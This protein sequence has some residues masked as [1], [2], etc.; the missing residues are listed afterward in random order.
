MGTHVMSCA[1]TATD[2]AIG[3]DGRV[4]IEGIDL[5]LRPSELVALIGN[6]GTGKSTLLD[7]LAGLRSPM[8][9]HVTTEGRDVRALS[10]RDRARR[11]AQV[12]TVRPRSGLLTVSALVALGRHP[13]TDALGR[14]SEGDRKAV[15]DALASVDGISLADRAVATLS[16]GE[17]QKVMIARALAQDTPILLL[18]EPTAHL[19]ITNRAMVFAL[20]RRVATQRH[21]AIVCATHD[22]QHALALADRIL[23][24]RRDGGP[25]LGDPRMAVREGVIAAA[26]DGPD[27][28][29]DPATGAFRVFRNDGPPLTGGGPG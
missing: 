3:H 21:K 7:T 27:A 18:D 4:L 14:E 10:P 13:W 8:R 22:L 25:W 1:M 24:L 16:D 26:F 15:R 17:L 12:L 9:G 5:D 2:L 19:D 11:I 20:L 23:L 28:H 29:F 6:N